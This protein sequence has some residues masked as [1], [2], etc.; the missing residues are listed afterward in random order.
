MKSVHP[1][2][3]KLA[4]KLVKTISRSLANP[5]SPTGM[6]RFFCCQIPGVAEHGRLTLALLLAAILHL[7]VVAFLPLPRVIP[8]T[9]P[10]FNVRLA[11]A[12]PL[13][14]DKRVTL[15]KEAPVSETRNAKP[16]RKMPFVFSESA[17]KNR[18]DRRRNRPPA[19]VTV[20]PPAV[21][22]SSPPS[23]PPSPS[24]PSIESVFD[25][26]K[27]IVRDEARRR[28]PS[29]AEA[30]DTRDRPVLPELAKAL[31]KQKAGETQFADGLIK[32]VT[33][34]GKALCYTPL[35]E[36]VAHGGPIEPTIVPTNCP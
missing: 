15:S 28:A 27:G 8:F 23:L 20:E 36:I 21:S 13:T 10:E 4:N 29:K 5:P 25:S 19:T 7:L 9:Q 18:F 26:V 2:L 14:G 1:G 3:G 31:K 35:P 34:S 22:A 12:T 11:P 17:A 30:T 16:T 24:P 32:I 6:G 33:P